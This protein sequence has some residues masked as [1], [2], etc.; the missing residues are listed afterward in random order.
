MVAAGNMSTVLS[1]EFRAEFDEQLIVSS[2]LLCFYFF[3]CFSPF[4][5]MRNGTDSLT[6]CCKENLRNYR[7]VSLVFVPE[8][9][10]DAVTNDR[11]SRDLKYNIL[12]NSENRFCRLKS[13][14]TNLV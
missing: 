8:K 11:V 14:L 13:F 2:N 1:L 9:S 5:W 3:L 6:K 12:G 7:T 4:G 10:V